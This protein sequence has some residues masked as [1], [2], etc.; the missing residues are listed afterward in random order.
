MF[1]GTVFADE[2]ITRDKINGIIPYNI[3]TLSK[4]QSIP[5]T[6][7]FNDLEVTVGLEMASQVSI[8]FHP[9]SR[10]VYFR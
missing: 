7:I 4:N 8:T 5:A 1:P 3:I 9:H 2:V 10:S 6:L